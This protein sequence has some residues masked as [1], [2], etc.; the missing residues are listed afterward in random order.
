ML[1]DRLNLGIISGLAYIEWIKLATWINEVVLH[2]I[3][4]VEQDWRL[5][6]IGVNALNKKLPEI[7]KKL[8]KLMKH[9]MQCLVQVT[10]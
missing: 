6:L 9:S 5:D 4:H 8:L 1:M 3:K 2:K 7:W 10:Y